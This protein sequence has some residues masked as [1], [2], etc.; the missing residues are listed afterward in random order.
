MYSIIL[1]LP[2]INSSIE[3]NVNNSAGGGPLPP[4]S[5]LGPLINTLKGTAILITIIRGFNIRAPPIII[6][7]SLYY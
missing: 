5:P 3:G 4:L 1:I 2:S 6:F 7:S